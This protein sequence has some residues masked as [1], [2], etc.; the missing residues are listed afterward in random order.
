MIGILTFHCAKNYGAVMQSF[1]LK[2]VLEKSGHQVEFINYTPIT[3]NGK[4][5]LK[6]GSI[7][8]QVIFKS[9]VK[10]YLYP[11][12]ERYFSAEDLKNKILQYDYCIVGSDQVWNMDFS[13]KGDYTFFLDFVP[14]AIPKISYAASLGKEKMGISDE[15]SQKIST[16]LKRF[17]AI[18]LR[19]KTGSEFIDQEF[20][21]KSSEVLDPTFLLDRNQYI[22]SLKIKPDFKSN[23]LFCFKFLKDPE[24][25]TT[26][27]LLAKKHKLEVVVVGKPKL[28]GG[29]KFIS[30]PTPR[31]WIQLFSSSEYIFTDSFHGLAFA[32]IFKKKFIVSPANIKRFNRIKNILDN[33]GLSDRIY[34]SYN[35]IIETDKWLAEIDYNE[36]DKII[37]EQR[38][39]SFD[40]LSKNLNH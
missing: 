21:L 17:K 27:K 31:K 26:I 32:I 38:L 2:T 39:K 12:S 11:I 10:R 29:I 4:A 40:F 5:S 35:D 22:S 7:I 1:A 18:S 34:Y 19:E 37:D 3:V 9:F 13:V 30:Y 24:F 15:D 36:V 20:N 23:Q 25:Y 16:L 28:L 8:N 33:L 14:D 6:V